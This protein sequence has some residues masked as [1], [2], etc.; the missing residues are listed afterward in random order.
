MCLVGDDQVELRGRVEFEQTAIPPSDASRPATLR[1]ALGAEHQNAFQ[2]LPCRQLLQ[3]QSGL[4]RLPDADAV[5][6]Q[7]TGPI[8]PE[9]AEHRLEQKGHVLDARRSERV[10]VIDLRMTEPDCCQARTEFRQVSEAPVAQVSGPVLV[11]AEFQRLNLVIG[12][13]PSGGA[14]Q[15][16]VRRAVTE[17]LPTAACRDGPGQRQRRACCLKVRAGEK[18]G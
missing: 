17:E 10:D 4:D 15:L 11:R 2:L 18:V 5:G 1:S 6:Y 8:C 13:S 14:V 12:K 3:D 9:Q 16:L 7:K